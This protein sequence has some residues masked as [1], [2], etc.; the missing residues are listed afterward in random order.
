MIFRFLFKLE[1][2]RQHFFAYN[3]FGK[4]ISLLF[5]DIS[6]KHRNSKIASWLAQIAL[7]F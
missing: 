5:G 6:Y 3:K 7:P 4:K 2:M 1:E